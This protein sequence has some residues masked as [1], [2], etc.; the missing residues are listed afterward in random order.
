MILMR[1]NFSGQWKGWV[2]KS[3]LFWA[4]MALAAFVAIS[5]P[6]PSNGPRNRCCPH[7]NHFVPAH[8]TTGTLIVI[9]HFYHFLNRSFLPC[10]IQN[11]RGFM[12][13]QIRSTGKIFSLLNCP[14]GSATWKIVDRDAYF[15]SKAK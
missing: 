7:Q 1:A 12:R 9:L 11:Q 15:K 13:I 8:L 5:G 4:Q 2:L 3:R 10:R 14:V 6:T